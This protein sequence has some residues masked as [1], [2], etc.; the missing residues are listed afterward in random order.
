MKTFFF[1]VSVPMTIFCRCMSMFDGT[2][3]SPLS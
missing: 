2:I 1:T 3:D